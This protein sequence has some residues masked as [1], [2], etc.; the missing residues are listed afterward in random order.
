MKNAK[1]DANQKA[2]VAALREA[3]ASVQLLHRVGGGCPDLLI[4]Y[5]GQNILFECKTEKG[6]L[7]KSQENW[8]EKWNGDVWVIRNVDDVINALRQYA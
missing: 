3:G 8:F 2:I 5:H 6:R 7:N 4:G 1:T